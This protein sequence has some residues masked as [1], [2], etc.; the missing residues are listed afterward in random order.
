[1]NAYKV[2]FV[3]S[4]TAVLTASVCAQPAKNLNSA[5]SYFSDIV[6]I[7]TAN[8]GRAERNYAACLGSDNEGVVES[9]L[10]QVAMM[11][12]MYPVKE[13]R[14]LEVAVAEVASEN[15]SSEI[16]YKAFLVGVLLSNPKQFASEAR[17]NYYGPDE[18]FGALAS[19]IHQVIVSN[20]TK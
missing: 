11:K 12:L 17:T 9:A 4:V 7:Q 14:K 18:L 8:L 16:R 5:D 19:R 1:M 13:F 6:S 15:A 10:S 20:M 3:A 2:L